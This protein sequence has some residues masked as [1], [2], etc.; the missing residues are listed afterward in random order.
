M[1]EPEKPVSQEDEE[2][3][4]KARLKADYGIEDAPEQYRE[5]TTRWG[6]VEQL[7]AQQHQALLEHQQALQQA[8]ERLVARDVAA[9]RAT[10]P[11]P[12]LDSEDELRELSRIDPYSGMQKLLARERAQWQSLMARGFQQIHGTVQSSLGPVADTVLSEQRAKTESA[13]QQAYPEA[14][15]TDS[16]LHRMTQQIYWSETPPQ[17]RTSPLAMVSAV[18]RAAGR[19]GIAPM[20]RRGSRADRAESSDAQSAERGARRPREREEE[21][22]KLTEKEE[23]LAEDMGLD[24][25]IYAKQK[26]EWAGRLKGMK[27]GA[28]R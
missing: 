21:M 24:K 14:Y 2:T 27:E 18:E 10:D 28:R 9:A 20:A 3:K 19:L 11:P 12:K 1:A 22:P 5:K 6:Q 4:F 25:K 16:D 17:E 7:A 23:T 15:E 13:L 8:A 26:K